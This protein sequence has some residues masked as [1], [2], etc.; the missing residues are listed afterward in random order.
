MGFDF[1]FFSFKNE[2]KERNF[3]NWVWLPVLQN[4]ADEAKTKINAHENRFVDEKT[5]IYHH[6]IYPLY[7]IHVHSG[8]STCRA[9]ERITGPWGSFNFGP[10]SVP[11]SVHIMSCYVA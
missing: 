11:V 9:T 6:E 7:G 10:P 5:N 4:G 8:W 1:R 2:S 3:T